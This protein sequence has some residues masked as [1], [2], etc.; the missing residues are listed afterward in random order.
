V[1]SN[2]AAPTNHINSSFIFSNLFEVDDGSM[3]ANG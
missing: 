1:G 2:P 3:K